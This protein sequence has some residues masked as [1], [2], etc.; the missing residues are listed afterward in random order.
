M[1]YRIN[2]KHLTNVQQLPPGE[3]YDYFVKRVADWQ[4]AWSIEGER[5]WLTGVDESGVVHI[6]LWSHPV[7][8]EMC[9]AGEWSRGKAVRIGLREL[10]DKMLPQLEMDRQMLSVMPVPNG[11]GVSIAPGRLK[12]DLQSELQKIE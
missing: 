5:G 8:A 10:L 3:R 6:P 4:E 11:G 9:T 2:A 7:F 1:T 12:E